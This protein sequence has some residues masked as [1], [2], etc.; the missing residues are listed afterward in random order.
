MKKQT[1]SPNTDKA[2]PTGILGI[3][4]AV[5]AGRLDGNA[6]LKRELG[7]FL[8][9]HSFSLILAVLSAWLGYTRT[10]SF[11]EGFQNAE[12]IALG[13]TVFIAGSA[14][15]FVSHAMG[16]VGYRLQGG[17]FNKGQVVGLVL[18]LILAATIITL[19]LYVN[20]SSVAPVVEKL[21]DKGTASQSSA[22]MAR[23]DTL[24]SKVELRQQEMQQLHFIYRGQVYIPEAPTKWISQE[25]LDEYAALQ[26]ELVQ[27]RTTKSQELANEA[28]RVQDDQRS[29]TQERSAKVD[30]LGM[31][32][33]LMY[34]LMI[35]A[36]TR[37]GMYAGAVWA[38]LEGEKKPQAAPV[39]Q[40]QKI[41]Q[42]N[43][44]PNSRL[45][46]TSKAINPPSPR[47]I[48]HEKYQRFL[49]VAQEVLAERGRYVKTDI[50]K[51]AG[52]SRDTVAIYLNLGIE[53][54]DLEVI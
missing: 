25:V 27:L 18:S 29:Y 30:M 47:N 49:R 17:Q 52:I 54:R 53:K 19:D 13:I 46:K 35:I 41:R 22:I 23:Y 21:T 40:H 37:V 14:Y 4:L 36:S 5:F 44:L 32:V 42:V 31:L 51:K 45:K 7:Y 12:T 9:L 8:I 6:S 3:V 15:L 39:A 28:A 50:A 48:D 34:F 2:I 38:Y 33:G 24:I 11:C 1:Q 16:Q 43:G 10:L 26:K 20:F